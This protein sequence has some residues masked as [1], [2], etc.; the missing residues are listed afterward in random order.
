MITWSSYTKLGYCM[1]KNKSGW[2]EIGTE[3]LESG[4]K[5]HERYKIK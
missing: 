3:E 5:E 1:K 2:S 4:K